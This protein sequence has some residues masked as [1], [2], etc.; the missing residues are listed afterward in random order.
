MVNTQFD[1]DL[2]EFKKI[3]KENFKDKVIARAKALYEENLVNLF[4]FRKRRNNN[5]NSQKRLKR[6]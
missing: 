3:L 4:S 6:P 5:S 1:N 2:E